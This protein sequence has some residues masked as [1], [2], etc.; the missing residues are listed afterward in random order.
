MFVNGKV[1]DGGCSFI[2]LAS[3]RR[4]GIEGKGTSEVGNPIVGKRGRLGLQSSEREREEENYDTE[5]S[6]L[7]KRA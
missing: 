2:C 6:V 1:G 3:T 7:R 4:V 5:G